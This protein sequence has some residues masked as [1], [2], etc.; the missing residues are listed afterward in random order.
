MAQD[1]QVET[2]AKAGGW[3]VDRASDPQAYVR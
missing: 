1:E 2:K 3:D